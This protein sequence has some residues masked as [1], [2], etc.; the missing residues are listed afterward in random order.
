MRTVFSIPCWHGSRPFFNDLVT[1]FK[2]YDNKVITFEFYRIWQLV[3]VF[4][5][6]PLDY[7]TSEPFWQ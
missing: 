6:K 4:F 5:G 7:L 2:K 3:V 1:L